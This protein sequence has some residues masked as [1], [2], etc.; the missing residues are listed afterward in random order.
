MNL[1][2]RRI[3]TCKT[4]IGMLLYKCLMLLK[5]SGIHYYKRHE[6]SYSFDTPQLQ[7]KEINHSL[8]T[9]HFL[10]CL[11]QQYKHYLH[12]TGQNSATMK[13]NGFINETS[14]KHGY[15]HYKK[16]TGFQEHWKQQYG[17]ILGHHKN[18]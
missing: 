12:I 14:Q 15:K 7:S 9:L 11:L 2:C 8:L 17:D 4:R 16:G 3:L 10:C 13:D 6:V 1:N 5:K 18:Q